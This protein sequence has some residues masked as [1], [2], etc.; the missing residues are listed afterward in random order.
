ME[1]L[2]RVLEDVQVL[3]GERSIASRSE[4][5]VRIDDLSDLF[6]LDGLESEEIAAA[7]TQD[8]YNALHNDL[9]KLHERLSGIA[10]VLR[11]RII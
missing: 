1:T 6:K 5:A 4:A 9:R 7:P 2:S 8:Q 3:L 10:A 11:N